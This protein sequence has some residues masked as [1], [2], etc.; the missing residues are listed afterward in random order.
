[1]IIITIKKESFIWMYGIFLTQKK[2][3]IN[4]DKTYDSIDFYA[5][6]QEELNE[7]LFNFEQLNGY[8]INLDRNK[9][10]KQ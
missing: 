3:S 8:K 2:Q 6:I 7:Y 4:P 5:S 1:M 10:M 9:N